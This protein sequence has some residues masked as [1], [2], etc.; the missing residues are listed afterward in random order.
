MGG[1]RES[2]KSWRQGK[3]IFLD[4]MPSR[5][6]LGGKRKPK[7]YSQVA[8]E[9]IAKE[10]Q[11]KKWRKRDAPNRTRCSLVLLH[12][13]EGE[14][15]NFTK[16]GSSPLLRAE[17]KVGERAAERR[18]ASRRNHSRGRSKRKSTGGKS[19]I[20][21]SVRTPATQKKIA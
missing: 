14:G 6:A 3:G 5:E 8:A 4:R 13:R 10:A 20:S 21:R 1:T 2:N 15:T 9:Q 17:I 19:P 16:Q 12:K 11:E 7:I 18:K